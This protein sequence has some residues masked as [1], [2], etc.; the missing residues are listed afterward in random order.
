WISDRVT[1]S[2]LATCAISWPST[3]SISSRDMA[4]SNPVETATRAEFLNA[5]VAKALGSPSYMATSGIA[6]PA[7]SA[8]RLTVASSQVS[9]S[10]RGAVMTCAPVD[11]LAIVFDSNREMN[12]PPKPIT[13][14]NTSSAPRLSPFAASAWL[15][16][17][18]SVTIDSTTI[19]A[20][21]VMRNRTMRFMDI[22]AEGRA[23]A[24]LTPPVR[25]Q[26]SAPRCL[27]T[28]DGR[29][30]APGIAQ[31]HGAVEDRVLRVVVM[32]I[33]DEIAVALELVA[34]LAWC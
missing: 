31:R 33:G 22:S 9:L 15:S 17:S 29:F 32:G 23:G 18:T 27:P 10:L 6:T 14:E 13:A 1:M 3:A 4:L 5:P 16:P 8:R 28:V 34:R 30:L 7:L 11:H 24:I 19:T 2:P 21:L 26:K 12:A 25:R 20:R